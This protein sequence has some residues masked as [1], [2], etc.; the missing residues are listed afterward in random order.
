M[1]KPERIVARWSEVSGAYIAIAP[2]GEKWVSVDSCV[3]YVN[4]IGGRHPEKNLFEWTS[5][6][7]I[8]GRYHDQV[9]A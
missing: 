2:N 6:H 1:N 4:T 5:I 8:G 3:W 7:L 9:L